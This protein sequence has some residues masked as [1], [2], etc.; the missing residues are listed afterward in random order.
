MDCFAG[1]KSGI[2]LSAAV[3]LLLFFLLL[4]GPAESL[5]KPVPNPFL[6]S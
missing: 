4:P 5:N 3:V 1:K 6:S 2:S